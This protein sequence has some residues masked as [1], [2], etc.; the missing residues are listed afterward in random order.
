M[1]ISPVDQLKSFP[2]C[3]NFSLQQRAAIVEESQD[4]QAAKGEV[5]FQ[6]GDEPTHLIFLLEGKLEVRGKAGHISDIPHTSLVGEMGV[7]SG[8]PRSATVSAQSDVRFLR[9]SRES[10]QRLIDSD[11][12]LGYHFFR[13][14]TEILGRHLKHNNLMMEFC[15]ILK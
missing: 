6:E 7:V 13:N 2:A 4:S 11:K 9:L 10:F 15:Q 1:K 8:E 12:D 14:L 5:L 3:R